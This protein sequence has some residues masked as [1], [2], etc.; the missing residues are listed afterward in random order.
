MGGRNAKCIS[1][2]REPNWFS[3]KVDPQNT[4]CTMCT[5]W[6]GAY[7]GWDPWNTERGKEG[8]ELKTKKQNPVLLQF[9]A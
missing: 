2:V 1:A 9:L 8:V 5:L 4:M 3:Y 7:A 6:G